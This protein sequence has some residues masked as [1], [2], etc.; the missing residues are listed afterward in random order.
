M[1]TSTKKRSRIR[2]AG[3][4]AYGILLLAK[5]ALMAVVA[6]LLLVAGTW[7][8]WDSA[9]H[10]MFTDGREL[11]TMTVKACGAD[12][13]TGPFVPNDGQGSV[14]AKVSMKKPVAQQT[15]ERL[16]V[17]VRPGTD[18][19]VRTGVPGILYAWVPL[20]G[21]MLLAALVL[22]GGLRMRRTGW[23]LGLLGAGLM[24][25]AFITL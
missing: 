17:A 12:R 6:L 22:A 21:A 13:C 14:R 10:A 2:R 5:N 7:T 16:P 23:V 25:A 3:E 19:V 4:S 8:S 11:G 18:D 20:G 24:G 9:R 15:G 1:P